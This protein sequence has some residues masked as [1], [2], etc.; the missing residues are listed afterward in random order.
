MIHAWFLSDLHLKDLEERNS[1]ILLRF[2]LL[3]NENKYPITHLILLGDIFDLWIGGHQVFIK[4]WKP[5]LDEIEKLKTQKNVQLIFV[6]GNHDVHI[7]P[8]W[9]KQL[10]AKVITDTFQFNLESKIIYLEH[11]DLI[12]KQD[13]NYL[14]YRSLIRSLP[15]RFLGLNLPGVFWESLGSWMSRT[16]AKKSRVYREDHNEKMRKLIRE[17]SINKANNM[18]RDVPDFIITGHFHIKDDF[19]FFSLKNKKVKSIN[20]GSWSTEDKPAYYISSTESKFVDIKS[21]K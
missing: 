10:G 18:L 9:E 5:I 12:N 21:L 4:K 8:Y 1:K 19:E 2:L 11:G 17:Y 14:K 16:S 13:K 20:L 3:L 15:L 6:E 7:D